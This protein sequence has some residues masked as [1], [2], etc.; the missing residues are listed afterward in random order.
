VEIDHL[1]EHNLWADLAM[2]LERGGVFYATYQPMELGTLVDLTVMLPDE[3]EPIT[4]AGVVRWTRPHL[5]GSEGWP[6]IGI[7]FIELDAVTHERFE[8]FAMSRQPIVFELDDAPIRR[9][10]KTG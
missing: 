8:R 5:E 10:G 6:G 4:V 3:E 1:S 2:Q 7:K 9:R